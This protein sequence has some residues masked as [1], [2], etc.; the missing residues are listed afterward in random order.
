[1][2]DFLILSW[3]GKDFVE[4]RMEW[5]KTG[6]SSALTSLLRIQLLLRHNNISYP[7]F[8]KVSS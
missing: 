8:L 3:L 4:K 5:G 1:M 2:S 7:V 6:E